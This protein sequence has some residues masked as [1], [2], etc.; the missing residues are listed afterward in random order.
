MIEEIKAEFNERREG[1]YMQI[2]EVIRK[3]RKENNMTQ[4]EM[5]R[6]LGATAPAVNKWENGN[7]FPDILL[8]SPIAGLLGITLD[9]PLSSQEELT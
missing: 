7:S 8:L 5:A 6:H 9:T 2:G 3:Y 1:I 4:K